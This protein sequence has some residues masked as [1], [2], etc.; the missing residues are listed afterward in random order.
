MVVWLK[1]VVLGIVEGATEFLPVSSTGHL[2]IAADVLNFPVEQ[3]DTFEIFIQLG[4]ILAVFWHYRRDLLDLARRAPS[5][6][7]AQGLIGK[8]LLAFVPAAA[9][10]F[11]IHHWIEDHLFSVRAVAWALIVGG[12]VIWL[13][14][15]R[16]RPATVTRLEATRWR[17]A[18][19][20]G[21]AQVASLYPGTSRAAAT[22]V[23]GLL[24]GLDRPTAT[25]FSFYLAL[26]TLTAASLFSLLK[27][28]GHIHAD[29]A[30]A[31]AL[32]LVTAFISALLVIRAFLAFVQTHDFRPFAYYRIVVGVLLL[33]WW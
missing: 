3:R 2:I 24:S 23:G 15:R 16:P 33:L 21:I 28:V 19:A 1:A 30:V 11:L 6:P 14:E 22:I 7:A 17:D 5:D 31:L 27:D 32:G 20:V 25:Q 13:I 26:P 8:V 12:I 4:A 10:G 18:V 29:E 9:V